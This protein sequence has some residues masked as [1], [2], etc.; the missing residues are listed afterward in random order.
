MQHVIFVGPQGAGKGKH[1][2]AVAP[3]LGL[4]HLS[5]GDLLREIMTRE[6][7]LATEVRGYYD[8]G[9]LVPDETM[10]RVL[11]GALD[12]RVA[13]DGVAGAVFDGFPRNRAQAEILDRQIADRGERLVAVVYIN[14]PRD[15]LMERLSGR[16]VCRNCGRTYHKVFNPPSVP[17]RCDACG[18]EL[19]QRSDDTPE[20]VERRLNIYFE[21][22][23]PLLDLWRERRLVR[24]ID[25]NQAVERVT[26]D[27]LEA[28]AGDLSRG[29]E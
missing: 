14:V 13:R 2:A 26:E 29:R 6:S 8:R 28:L 9:E 21:Q 16:L 10:A 19:Y 3:R 5:T 7:S 18:G 17:G 12:E 20:A 11:F 25:G 4:A 23:E 24:R 1:A 15:V 22:T 27:I